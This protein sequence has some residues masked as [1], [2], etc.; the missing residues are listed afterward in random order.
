ML[1]LGLYV[2]FFFYGLIV[3]GQRETYNWYFGENAGLNFSAGSP[4]VLLNGALD[5]REGCATISDS[6]GQLLFYT[7]G[8]TV[9]NRNHKIMLNG[10][11]LLG[12]SSSTHSAIIVPKPKSQNIYYIFTIATNNST[13]FRPLAFSEVNM[14]L[15]SGLGGITNIKNKILNNAVNEKVSAVKKSKDDPNYW[16]VSHTLNSNKFI[17]FE[18]TESGVSSTPIESNVGSQTG[19]FNVT[20]QMKISPR[21]SKL[22][23]VRGGEVQLFDFNKST[24]RLTNPITLDSSRLTYGA[25]FSSS[26]NLLYVSFFGGVLQY[27]LLAGSPLDIV[28]S[29]IIVA[30]ETNSNF[31]SLQT[32]PDG[33]IYVARFR[34]KALDYIEN[35]NV[36]GIGCNYTVEG[37]YLGGRTSHLGLPTFIQSFFRID[38]ITYKNTCFNDVTE[39]SLNDSFD[40]VLW[41]FGDPTTGI[42]NTSTELNPNHIFSK[43]GEYT[44]TITATKNFETIADTI[45]LTISENPNLISNLVQLQQCDNDTDG[46]T[47]FN[48]NEVKEKLIINPEEHSITFYE[49][50]ALAENK[51]TEILNIKNYQNEQVS[52]DTI[53]ARVENANGCYEVSEVNLL[54]STT[55]IP[56]NFLKSFYECD[57]GTNSSDGIATFNFSEVTNEIINIFPANQQLEIKYFKN[58]ADALAEENKIDKISNYQNIDSPNQQTIYIRVDSKLDNSCLGLGAYITLYVEKVPIANSVNI[59][60]ECDNDR[61]GLF[62]FD[63]SSI[64]STIIGN[65]TNVIV[66][67]FDENGTQLSSPLPNPFVTASLKVTAR[68]VNLNSQ[69]KVGQCFDETTI[70]FVVSTV[71]IA[72]PIAPQEECDTDFDESFDFDTSAIESTILGN[73]SG[74]IVKYFDEN[75]SPLPSPLPNPF[76]TTNQTIR[77]RIENPI[78]DVCFEETTIDFIVHKKPTFDLIQE[79]V[80]CMTQNPKQPISIYNPSGNFTYTW[81]DENGNIVGIEPTIEVNKGGIYKVIATSSNGC[82]SDEESI[83]LRE[84]SLSII[85]INNIQVQDDSDNNFIKINTSNLGLGD[86]EF[87]LL[88]SESNI[89]F[90]YQNNPLFENLEGGNYIL[91]VNDKNNCGKIPLEIALISFP[92]FFTPNGDST[93]DYWQIKGINKSIYKS[94]QINIYNRYGKLLSTFTINDLGWDGTYNGKSLPANDFWFRVVLVN[95][96]DNI[97][98]RTGNFSLIR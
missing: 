44:I 49:E 42:N 96:N 87:R 59:N 71:P 78:Y 39:F 18:V 53:W 57:D 51:G 43:P 7:D 68:I 95:Q 32:G 29:E 89:I 34:K 26:G 85:S 63:T 27:N 1:R 64:Q 61:D 66:S 41:N 91:E 22:V 77:V 46:F 13:T 45:T 28:D 55:Q 94:G 25:E 75:N 60:P 79:D 67:Y 9:Y 19:F 56:L 37:V 21:N 52:N 70:D 4:V 69:D 12:H 40:S 58:E 86:Y 83:I 76:S 17:T 82:N 6:S 23:A 16:V 54:V 35:P 11:N 36:Q 65:Q 72:N 92:N 84:S 30:S 90:D 48:L 33:K 47:L 93:N 10:E 3:F 50:K 98:T 15:D 62:S 14:K 74:L 31:H 5:T 20:G 2:F 81:R 97:K 88:D 80:I 73:Q 8:V 24:G 38:N